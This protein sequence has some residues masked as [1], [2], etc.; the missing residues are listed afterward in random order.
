LYI[1]KGG[2]DGDIL[3]VL[4]WGP[5]IT[6]EWAVKEASDINTSHILFR[7]CKEGDAYIAGDVILSYVLV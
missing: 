6:M 4:V 5:L 3:V 2:N 7:G 1:R